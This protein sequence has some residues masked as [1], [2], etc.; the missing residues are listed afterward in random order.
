MRN[1]AS[2]A[3]DLASVLHVIKY[4]NLSGHQLY[5]SC[6]SRPSSGNGNL[7]GCYYVTQTRNDTWAGLFFNH[8]YVFPRSRINPR[9]SMYN[10]A[11][12]LFLNQLHLIKIWHIYV[13]STSDFL[14]FQHVHIHILIFSSHFSFWSFSHFYHFLVKLLHFFG[15]LSSFYFRH[16]LW[17]NPC[18]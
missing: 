15:F 8:R 5:F 9:S 1:D 16:D 18:M 13:R 14:D 7:F 6:V 17:V 2:S 4:S 12:C 11:L 3:L 10:M